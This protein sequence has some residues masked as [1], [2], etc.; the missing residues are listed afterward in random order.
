[1]TARRQTSATL[2]WKTTPS[3]M[4][5]SAERPTGPVTGVTSERE[6]PVVPVICPSTYY[7]G[8]LHLLVPTSQTIGGDLECE[9]IV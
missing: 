7:G 4:I 5:W 9:P 3:I 8:I 6:T 1:M 2:Q